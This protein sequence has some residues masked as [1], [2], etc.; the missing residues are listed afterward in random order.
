MNLE[1]LEK[2]T[3]QSID[4]WINSFR[5][6]DFD[7][8]LLKPSEDKWSMGQVGIHCWMS[9]KGFFFKNAEK[10]LSKDGT[11]AGKSMKLGAHLIFTLRMLP[12][13]KY[14]MPKQ[15]AV[16]PKQ[17]ESKGQ[18]ISKLEEVKKIAS[19][20]IQRIPQSDPR[21]KTKHPFLG[22]LNT[23]EWISLCNIHFR[24]HVRQKERIEKHFGWK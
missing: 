11:Q 19:E 5:Q 6:Y 17:P 3:H 24:H 13:V 7:K 10:C 16:I 15:V 9:A 2:Q 4:Y 21:L 14:E 8:I 22:W 12:P 18:L 23:A 20:Y 1:K